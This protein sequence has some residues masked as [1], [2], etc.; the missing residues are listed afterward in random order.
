M[1]ESER[2]AI[3]E[4]L[5]RAKEYSLEIEVVFWAMK[6]YAKGESIENSCDYALDEWDV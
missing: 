6:F 5:R 2:T 3:I 4:M 1:N